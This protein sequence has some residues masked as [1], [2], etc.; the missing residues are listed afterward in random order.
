MVVFLDTEFSDMVHPELL[1]VGLVDE[2][3]RALYVELD[4]VGPSVCSAFVQAAVLPLLQGPAVSRARA[5]ELLLEYLAAYQGDD[6]VLWSDSPA[7]DV[8]LLR[9][10][11]EVA[12]PWRVE[13]PSFE[14][15]RHQTAYYCAVERAFTAGLRRHHALDDAKAAR[16]GW[17][18]LQAMP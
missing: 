6:V 12:P 3:G 14:D 16:A 15:D 11:F 5:E 13:V 10:L 4:D 9:E 2:A 17:L 7:Y 1:S 8:T 18:A